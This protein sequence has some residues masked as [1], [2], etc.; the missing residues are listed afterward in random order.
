MAES[1]PPPP[2]NFAKI[3]HGPLLI[4]TMLNTLLYGISI[5]QTF[6]YFSTFKKDRTWMKLVV[7]FIFL[8]DTMNSVFDIEYIYNALV[9]NYNNP[10]AIM[11]ANWVFGT[12]P[13]MTAIIGAT[14]QIFFAWRVKVLTNSYIASAFIAVG[15]LVECL[16]GIGT[17]IAIGIVPQWLEFQKF[18][19]TVIIWLA[20][21][22]VTDIAITTILV[23]HLRRHKGSF[24]VSNDI[25]DK[26]IRMTVQTGLVTSIWATLDLALYLG[27]PNSGAHLAFN[28]ALSKLYSNSLLSSLNSRSGWKF[29]TQ[30]VS[31]EASSSTG[32]RA[33]V[34]TFG[35]SITRPEVFIDVESHEMANTDSKPGSV[36]A[37]ERP[38]RPF[39]LSE[40]PLPP[41]DSMV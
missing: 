4:G 35:S 16:G 3:A 1:A 33:N 23:W 36:T 28:L 19:V 38:P 22:T 12:D 15:A 18:K 21:S 8:A 11:K 30:D 13:A 40:K 32:R 34:L 20:A 41:P 10:Q 39:S 14:V 6:I 31:T 17:S 5:T 26:L 2:F 37:P 9:N 29:G 24:K 25:L 27:V 7:L